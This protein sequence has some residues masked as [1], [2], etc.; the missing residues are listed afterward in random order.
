MRESTIEKKL[1]TEAK[2]R[3][4]M[5]AKFVSPGMNGMP[6]RLVM[7]PGGRM[8]FVELKAPGKK[9]RLVQ[10]LRM[11]QL[12]RLGFYAVVIDG[13]EQIGGVLDEIQAS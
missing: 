11:R 5:A 4:G 10:E 7:M 1:V 12:R 2:A 6:D 3:G 9:P 8:G 13:T